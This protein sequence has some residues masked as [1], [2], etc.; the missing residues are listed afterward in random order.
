MWALFRGNCAL[1]PHRYAFGFPAR[2]GRLGSFR[3]TR[4]RRSRGTCRAR[5]YPATGTRF[6]GAE[7]RLLKRVLVCRTLRSQTSQ[8]YPWSAE[9]NRP[10]RYWYAFLPYR[11]NRP[12]RVWAGAVRAFGPSAA[13]RC[14]VV[15]YPV[16][17][18]P[19]LAVRSL[20]RGLGGRAAQPPEPRCAASPSTC[21]L[22]PEHGF[23][24][25]LRSR[26]PATL[27]HRCLADYEIYRFGG[28]E[29]TQFQGE[30]TLTRLLHR[31][32]Q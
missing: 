32:A 22:H 24:R 29:L 11:S 20:C 21:A 4:R 5:C 23:R 6:A 2:T 26:R 9:R 1:L 15:Q 19:Q 31:T 7:K 14:G 17:N 16:R 27:R 12:V 18:A 10:L 25:A 3:V 8:T 28:W 13:D 30:Q